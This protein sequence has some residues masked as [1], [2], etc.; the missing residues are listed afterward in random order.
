[1]KKSDVIDGIQT[2]VMF[3]V[4]FAL[5]ILALS[6]FSG[7]GSTNSVCPAYKPKKQVERTVM[8]SRASD[9]KPPARKSYKNVPGAR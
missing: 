3:A 6:V 5:M 1:M 8:N 7:C 2:V 4:I 9:P